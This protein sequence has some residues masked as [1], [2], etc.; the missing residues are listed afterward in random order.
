[1]LGLLGNRKPD[2]A[3]IR[4]ALKGFNVDSVVIEGRR[5]SVV[6]AVADAREAESAQRAAEEKLGCIRGLESVRVI[7][8]A[9]RAANAPK[10]PAQTSGHGK[11]IA[12]SLTIA[13]R[14]IIAV[15]SGK[16]GV[17]KSTVAIN[18]AAALAAQGLD[19]G[20]LDADIYGPSLP[21]LAG[22]RDAKPE[23][24]DERIQPVRAHGLRLMSMGFMVAENAPMIWRGPMIQSALR[25]MLRDVVW[26]GCDVLVIDLPPGTGDVQL[27]LCQMAKLSGAV[28]IST[29]QD[30]ALADARKGLEMFRTLG[31]PIMGIVENMSYFCCPE[32]G[33]RA[34]IFGHGGA[35]EAAR[36]MGVP[37]LGEIPLDADIR[38]LSDAGTPIVLAR[39]ESA[40]AQG[41]SALAA[42]VSEAFIRL[43]KSA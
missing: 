17:G 16:G 9:A 11:G 8:T 26:D 31:V 38:A 18:L 25:Q 12:P 1:M 39:P 19:V 41:F 7:A 32:C 6:L 20:L 27:S 3:A 2:E 28:V 29:P 10:M 23:Y 14:H 30:I 21:R 34:E 22:L 37:F 4:A 13:V 36:E 40:Q 35:R 43:A 15:A 24:R 5:A 33:H 42:Q